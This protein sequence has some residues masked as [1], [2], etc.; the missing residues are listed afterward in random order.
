MHLAKSVTGEAISPAPLFWGFCSA[1]L[2]CPM[3]WPFLPKW[4]LINWSPLFSMLQMTMNREAAT[5]TGKNKR[6]ELIFLKY[7][8]T[9]SCALKCIF[10]L[11][12][13]GQ[14]PNVTSPLAMPCWILLSS[15]L[16]WWKK[17]LVFK[18]IK[19]IVKITQMWPAWVSK[20]NVCFHQTA[21]TAKSVSR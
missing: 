12:F 17:K 4:L 6:W 11:L 10:K 8:S 5:R 18:E 9:K 2:K 14:V 13:W 15:T 21:C 19:Q 20:F 1:E 7:L 16:Y 3:V